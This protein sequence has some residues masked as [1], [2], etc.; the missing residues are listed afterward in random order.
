M[1]SGGVLFLLEG[2]GLLQEYTRERPGMGSG[3][4]VGV[5]SGGKTRDGVRWM[6]LPV[7]LCSVVYLPSE[8]F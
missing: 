1:D 2:S 8:A 3:G 5:G 6:G 7:C 4:G